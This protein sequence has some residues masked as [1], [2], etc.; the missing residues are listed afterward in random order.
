MSDRSG[1]IGAPSR[2]IAPG[3]NKEAVRDRDTEK[4]S[5]KKEEANASLKTDLARGHRPEN[6]ASSASSTPASRAEDYPATT[7]P[8]VTGKDPARTGSAAG[9]RLSSGQ[10]HSTHA[11]TSASQ[12]A[13]TT[14]HDALAS[15]YGT[16]VSDLRRLGYEGDLGDI[17]SPAEL[18]QALIFALDSRRRD[19]QFP[20]FSL[21]VPLIA[22]GAHPNAVSSSGWA[23]LHLA[24][25]NGQLNV[26]KVLIAKGAAINACGSGRHK[27]PLDLAIAEYFSFTSWTNSRVKRNETGDWV[28]VIE[29]L[30]QH[31]ADTGKSLEHKL[32]HSGYIRMQQHFD[33]FSDRPPVTLKFGHIHLI[34]FLLAQGFYCPWTLYK[35]PESAEWDRAP[36]HAREI[37]QDYCAARAHKELDFDAYDLLSS[38]LHPLAAA[39]TIASS[40]TSTSSMANPATSTTTSTEVAVPPLAEL[41]LQTFCKSLATGE[42]N[43]ES[44]ASVIGVVGGMPSSA[45][46]AV[47]RALA[48]AW[49]C[50]AQMGPG[51]LD[52]LKVVGLQATYEADRRKFLVIQANINRYQANGQTLLTQAALAGDIEMIGILVR[53]RANVQLPNQSGHNAAAVAASAGQFAAVAELLS[54]GIHANKAGPDGRSAQYY[55]AA[56]I[57]DSNGPDV[58]AMASLVRYLLR[59]GYRFNAANPVY[60]SSKQYP[61][62]ADLLAS[63]P[64]RLLAL[65]PELF[66]Q[67]R[68]A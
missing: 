65:G 19:P 8:A 51:T 68:T 10:A 39:G 42:F 59:K 36:K 48:L 47:A 63:N 7:Q 49:V 60:A 37:F 53:L 5:E 64:E 66:V 18:T 35:L 2:Q 29:F 11:T 27:L 21:I 55:V 46:Q 32:M 28:G 6:S 62:L 61:T 33:E 43:L 15:S 50:G 44:I 54:H 12:T 31:H 30:V 25:E 14:P 4:S 20:L 67:L 56:A 22:A 40:P 1:G 9:M 16:L 3:G 38:T 58:K 34:R 41:A 24:A 17:P 57:A 13:A 26:V 52:A 23:P 45:Q